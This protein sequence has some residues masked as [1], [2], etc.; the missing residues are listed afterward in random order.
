MAEPLQFNGLPRCPAGKFG[1]DTSDV[2]RKIKA[3][4][5]PKPEAAES[6]VKRSSL[7]SRQFEICMRGI[8]ICKL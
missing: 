4:K 3:L 2:P 7:R 5:M 8:Q 6:T 1:R